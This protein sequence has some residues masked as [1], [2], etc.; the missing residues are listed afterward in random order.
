MSDKMRSSRLPLYRLQVYT[1]ITILTFLFIDALHCKDPAKALNLT[2]HMIPLLDRTCPPS[3][4]PTLAL[5]RLHQ[6]LLVSSLAS[7]SSSTGTPVQ[8]E[9]IHATARAVAGL[10]AVLEEGHPARGVLI[11]E[12]GKLLAMD[13]QPQPGTSSPSRINL[14]GQSEVFPPTGAARLELAID[15]LKRARK[16]LIIG[17]GESTEGGEVGVAMRDDIIALE[18][19]LSIWRRAFSNNL[20]SKSLA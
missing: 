13:E 14:S 8:D 10:T 18:T 4:H 6:L 17:F 15:T 11:A 9:A 19:E 1:N 3:S 7:T 5:L 20:Q 12:L 2:S 16:E